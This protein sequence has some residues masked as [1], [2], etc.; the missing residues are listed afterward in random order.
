MNFSSSLAATNYKWWRLTAGF[1]AEPDSPDI[2]SARA[3]TTINKAKFKEAALNWPV[4]H[5][6][7]IAS[8]TLGAD[9]VDYEKVVQEQRFPQAEPDASS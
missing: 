4:A 6:F 2:R 5:G 3:M 8:D 7:D 1:G 9:L